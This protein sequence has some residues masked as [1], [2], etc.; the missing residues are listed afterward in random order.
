MLFSLFKTGFLLELTLW[1]VRL[2]LPL[3]AQPLHR[4]VQLLLEIIF[5]GRGPAA[6]KGF[7]SLRGS[8]K[9]RGRCF[10]V[11]FGQ[12]ADYKY[13][14]KGSTCSAVTD[15]LDDHDQNY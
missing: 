2:A 15:L 7:M 3:S 12:E 10:P 4:Q 14:T 13:Q 8:F 6:A 1:P 5:E 11:A 9:C